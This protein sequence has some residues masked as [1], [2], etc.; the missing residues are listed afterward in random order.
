MNVKSAGFTTVED[1]A[2]AL[3]QLEDTVKPP[4]DLLAH[5]I[6]CSHHRYVLVQG[7]DE[8]VCSLVVFAREA[9]E[10]AQSLH[11]ERRPEYKSLS[12]HNTEYKSLSRHDTDYKSLSRHNLDTR[13]S[14]T[15]RR[16][17]KLNF[18][19]KICYPILVLHCRTTVLLHIS[20]AINR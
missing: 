15:C 11:R 19:S 6:D 16:Q 20:Q 1:G 13:L 14:V 12:R 10:F 8:L 5:L 3:I 9:E 17:S 18:L 2:V 7:S 4:V